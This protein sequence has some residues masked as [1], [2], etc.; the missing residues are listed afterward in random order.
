MYQIN[1]KLR[2]LVG[3]SGCLNLKETTVKVPY[4]I[5]EGCGMDRGATRAGTRQ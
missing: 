2:D 5:P 1:D 3:S 4:Y